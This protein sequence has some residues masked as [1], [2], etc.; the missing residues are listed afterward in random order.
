MYFGVSKRRIK[1]NSWH[2]TKP[3]KNHLAQMR[4]MVRFYRSNVFKALLYVL[5]YSNGNANSGYVAISKE[6][7]EGLT[8]FKITTKVQYNSFYNASRYDILH[9]DMTV[10]AVATYALNTSYPI[11]TLSDGDYLLFNG[12]VNGSTSK[13]WNIYEIA[14]F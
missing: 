14:F 1:W 2:F 4:E 7:L 9:S 5:D 3:L 11:P 8:S 13:K 10:T 6:A 12:R